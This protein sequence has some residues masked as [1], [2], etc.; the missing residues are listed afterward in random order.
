MPKRK[1]LDGQSNL[2]AAFLTYWRQI[3]PHDLPEP[4]HWHKV[5]RY[6]LDYS[7][8]EV[9]LSVELNGL[10]G[11]GYGRK[12]FCHNCGSVVHAK[13]KDGGIGKE[14][15]IPA[16]SHGSTGGMVRDAKKSNFLILAG[17]R[18]LTFTSR[19]VND[20]PVGVIKS[21]AVLLRD[22]IEFEKFDREQF[23]QEQRKMLGD[24]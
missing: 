19:Q 7:W 21:I 5:G 13:K 2:E 10:G 9:K 11:G 16:P 12:V 18:P 14:L 8:P 23:E 1:N 15:R 4:V 24:C 6:E 17:W 3:A 20:D 22:L